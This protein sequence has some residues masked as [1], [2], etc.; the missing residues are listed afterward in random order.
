MNSDQDLFMSLSKSINAIQANQYNQNQNEIRQQS[1]NNM[2]SMNMI[3]PMQ[4]SGNFSNQYNNYPSI[5]RA[6]NMQSRTQSNQNISHQTNEL[7][8]P[9]QSQKQLT[10]IELKKKQL[11]DK[12]REIAQQQF[13]KSTHDLT[14]KPKT[15]K[16]LAKEKPSKP[17]AEKILGTANNVYEIPKSLYKVRN[18]IQQ[19]SQRYFDNT[20]PL[21]QQQVDWEQITTYLLTDM[22]DEQIQQIENVLKLKYDLESQDEV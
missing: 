3:Q 21:Y 4:M 15:P 18:T 16:F 14:E 11:R 7:Q 6:D 20:Q 9:Q 13:L 5:H 1:M 10:G 8:Q 12:Q 22:T 19:K 2:Q 17:T